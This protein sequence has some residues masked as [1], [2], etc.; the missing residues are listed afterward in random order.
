MDKRFNGK[1]GHYISTEWL[2]K[3][4]QEIKREQKMNKKPMFNKWFA[5]LVCFSLVCIYIPLH[6]KPPKTAGFTRKNWYCSCGYE[7]YGRVDNCP[8]CGSP[9]PKK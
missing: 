5:I 6:A 7:N 4:E 2:D 9:R 3:E 1:A 8:I